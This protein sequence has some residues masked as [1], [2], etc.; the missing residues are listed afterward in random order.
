MP[1]CSQDCGMRV[2]SDKSEPTAHASTH[3]KPMGPG[4][5]KEDP[6]FVSLGKRKPGETIRKG[7]AS[8]KRE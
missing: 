5:Q 2:E 7:P 4:H 1:L 8:E 3:R 6:E